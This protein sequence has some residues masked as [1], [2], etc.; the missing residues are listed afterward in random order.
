MVDRINLSVEYYFLKNFS[1]AVL[2]LAFCITDSLIH[3]E[4]AMGRNE[5]SAISLFMQI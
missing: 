3:E 4:G 5:D 1:D 2:F